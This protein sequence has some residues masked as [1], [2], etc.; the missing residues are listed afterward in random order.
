VA[1]GSRG[2]TIVAW[3]RGGRPVAAAGSA[4]NRRFGATRTLS[5]R[6]QFAA[7]ITVAFGPGR[8]ALVA[9]SQGTLNPSVVAA[10]YTSS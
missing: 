6:A 7:D 1:V 5:S 4:R 9:W 8:Q 2:Q 10:P 3:I